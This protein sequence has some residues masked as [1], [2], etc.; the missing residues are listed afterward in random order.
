M[1]S[2]LLAVTDA[3]GRSLRM[4]LAARQRSDTVGARAL[5]SDLPDTNMSVVI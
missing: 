4:F 2:K 1:N 5:L 3:L